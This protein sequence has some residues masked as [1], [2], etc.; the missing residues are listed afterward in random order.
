MIEVII[1]DNPMKLKIAVN[2]FPLLK[3]MDTASIS[4]LCSVI[5]FNCFNAMKKRRSPKKGTWIKS[6]NLFFM[7]CLTFIFW[8]YIMGLTNG[9][10]VPNVK[11]I[12]LWEQIEKN[13]VKI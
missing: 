12:F 5:E 1:K 11:E 7:Y 4:R 13:W 8:L 2:G 6:W 9:T 10:S 3:N